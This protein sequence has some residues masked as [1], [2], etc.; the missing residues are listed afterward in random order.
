M[1]KHLLNKLAPHNHRHNHDHVC[2]KTADNIITVVMVV[3]CADTSQWAGA[4]GAFVGG[5]L[6]VYVRDDSK[7]DSCVAN[8]RRNIDRIMIDDVVQ[9]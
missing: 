5:R 4:V 6:Y 8:L 3:G 2:K 9:C 1:F 7:L